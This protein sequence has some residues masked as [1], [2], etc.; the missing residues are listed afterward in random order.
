[1][2]DTSRLICLDTTVTMP[3]G[4][5]LATD[6]T[7]ADDGEPHPVLL[8]RTPYGRASVRGHHDAIGMARLGWAVVTQD[9]RGR[10]DSPGTFAPFR[11]E[12]LDGAATVAWCASQP[13][14]NGAVAMAGGSYNGF[15]QWLAAAER[16]EALRVIMPAVAGPTV[17]DAVYEGGAL[18]L[19]VFSAWTLGIGAV[20]GRYDAELVKAAIADLDSWPGV[21]RSG[22]ENTTLPRISA[23][24]NRWL[25]PDDADLWDPLDASPALRAGPDAVD[26]PSA[27]QPA[28][29][30]LAGWHDLFCDAT[31]D[32]YTLLTGADI[33]ESA[34]RRQRL[35]VGPWSHASLLRRT[36]G[37]LDFG[38]AAQGDFNGI[39]EE[40]LAFL[41]AGIA[42]RDV[43]H[44]VR[45]FVMGAN[46]W[47]DLP[48]WPPPSTPTPLY[49]AGDDALV[50]GSPPEAGAD[51]YRHDPDDPVPT[52]GGR[53]LHPVPPEAGPLDQWD[54]EERPDVLVYT[55]A[56]LDRDLTVIGQV[57]AHVTFASTADVADLTVK[58][59][60][61]HPDGRAMLVVDSIRRVRTRSGRSVEVEVDVGATAMTFAAGHRIRVE[62]ASSNYPRFDLSPAAEQTVHRGG[63]AESRIVLPV[64]QT[65]EAVRP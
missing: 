64:H 28:G 37:R 3:D 44:G 19:G 15:T 50:W 48:S 62:I 16:P 39:A 35:V 1:V 63:R 43:P 60:D 57:R 8:M 13:W 10:W 32:G 5:A 9:V 38:V 65:V 31:I 17:R 6:V 53:T 41:T 30:H 42:D 45:V 29:Y 22:V 21:L 23:D 11:S 49:L 34:R 54:I 40:Q 47:L 26:R 2:G 7:V 46:R 25:D 24:W 12:R 20:G 14:S 18:Q 55:S 58:L 4:V 27:P 52:G 33:D 36:T 51:H 61:V 59:V 56:S